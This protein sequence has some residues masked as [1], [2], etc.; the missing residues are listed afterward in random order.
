MNIKAN[1]FARTD[2]GKKRQN[3]EDNFL[4]VDLTKKKTDLLLPENRTFEV[5]EFGI[6]LAVADGM[7]GAN[8]GEIASKL[9]LNNI[10]SYLYKN[11]D[12]DS[13]IDE[14]TMLKIFLDSIKY[15]NEK[16]FLES[17]SKQDYFGMGTTFTGTFIYKNKIFVAQIGDSRAYIYRNKNLTQITKDQTISELVK[18]SRVVPDEIAEKNTYKNIITQALGINEKINILVT[19]SEIKNDDLLLICSDGLTDLVSDKEI[20]DILSS[21]NDLVFLCKKL[22]DVANNKGGTDNITVVLSRF[23]GKDLNPASDSKTDFYIIQE[24]KIDYSNPVENIFLE[25]KNF[26]TKKKDKTALKA[27]NK[28]INKLIGLILVSVLII[29]VATVVVKNE[30]LANNSDADR[31]KTNENKELNIN[32]STS[33][34]KKIVSESRNIEERHAKSKLEIKNEKIM[35]LKNNAEIAFNDNRLTVSKD[36][37]DE[38]DY[39]YY[40]YGRILDLE[41]ENEEAQRGM[42]NIQEKLFSLANSSEKIGDLL[43]ALRHYNTILKYFKDNDKLKNKVLLKKSNIYLNKAQKAFN[44]NRLTVSKDGLDEND[45]AYYWYNQILKLDPENEKALIGIERIKEKLFLLANS[46]EKSGN[47]SRA[48]R[49]YRT[50]I[51]IFG[52]DKETKTRAIKA[53]NRIQDQKEAK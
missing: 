35:K 5:G 38:N 37:L 25:D 27:K 15:A 17:R 40:W 43:R 12:Y 28:K 16:L 42:Q 20:T 33:K 21:D 53:I 6:I 31:N 19:I 52:K 45:Y 46:N 47:F 3:N 8:A 29:I 44:D 23:S 30:F 51:E 7:G 39:A 50:I 34:S 18:R 49:H 10:L 9:S 13:K 14:L 2:I 24:N 48:M 4:L 36:G 32:E 11:I 26:S 1:L 41:P 22:T